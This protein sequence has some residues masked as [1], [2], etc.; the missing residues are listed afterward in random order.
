MLSLEMRSETYQWTWAHSEEPEP[1]S[2][3]KI[4][5]KIKF[6]EASWSKFLK[7]VLKNCKTNSFKNF[8]VEI[9]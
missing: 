4:C 1:K 8:E 2:L 9:L 7:K 3:S 5:M 6:K